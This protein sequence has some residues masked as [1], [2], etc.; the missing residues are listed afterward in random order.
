VYSAKRE[1]LASLLALALFVA[2]M[3]VDPRLAALAVLL[4]LL[5][6]MWLERGAVYAGRRALIRTRRGIYVNFSGGADL[7]KTLLQISRGM[8]ILGAKVEPRHLI[9]LAIRVSKK[10]ASSRGRRR[11]KGSAVTVDYVLPRRKYFKVHIPATLRRSAALRQFPRVSPESLRARLLAGR[12][13]V[14]LVLV[15]DSSASMIH[16]V[17]GILTALKAVEREVRRHRD[18]VAIVI[19]KGF[20]AAVLQ[21][22]TTNFNLVQ[23]KLLRLGLDNYTPLAAGMYLGLQVA[24]AEK[25]RGYEPILVVVSDG[26]ANV[27][28]ERWARAWRLGLDPAAQSVLEVARQIARNDVEVVVVNTQHR[29]PTVESSD[30]VLSGTTLL[31]NV[32]RITKGS[33]VGITG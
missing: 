24:I 11:M 25:R 4:W 32:A 7:R 18:R 27:P 17:R 31:I 26:N 9:E 21:H 22:P 15:L 16:S 6:N 5:L 23:S 20:G 12:A 13:K 1:L 10:R 28:L 29:E 2:L 3:F 33:Y 30:A 19:C 8:R 14:S